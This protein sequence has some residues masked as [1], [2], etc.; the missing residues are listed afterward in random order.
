MRQRGK[1]S[2]SH[3][4]L[5]RAAGRLGIATGLAAL[6]TMASVSH[7]AADLKGTNGCEAKGSIAGLDVSVA[8]TNKVLLPLKGEVVWSAAVAQAPG[9]YQGDVNLELPPPLGSLGIASF[10]GVGA[11]ASTS[12]TY[13]YDMPSVVPTGVEL[14][15]NG[16]QTDEHGSCEGSVIV[17]F[18]GDNFAPKAI[19]LGGTIVLGAAL[20]GLVKPAFGQKGRRA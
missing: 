9:A 1:M 7:A 3:S 11:N 16:R 4:G 10:S 20:G 6:L 12:G 2:T 18:Q 17:E 13:R 19:L 8:D 14:P 15:L 5:S